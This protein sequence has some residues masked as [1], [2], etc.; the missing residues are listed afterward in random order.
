MRFDN[1]LFSAY[2]EKVKKEIS[3]LDDFQLPTFQKWA[4]NWEEI[5]EIEKSKKRSRWNALNVYKDLLTNKKNPGIYY[6]MVDKKESKKLFELFVKSKSESSQIRKDS[7]VR[8]LG[9]KS[10]SHVPNEFKISDCIYVGSRKENINER[11]KQHLGYGHG[12]TGA[13]HMASVFASEISK[14]EITFYYHFLEGKYINLTE[15]IEFVVQNKLKP[16][17]GKN[18]LGD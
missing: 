9:F 14:P 13:L 8:A 2:A 16:F 7:G 5:K 12:R 17:I 10:I 11:F 18:I 6:F 3:L 15:H 1:S 4:I